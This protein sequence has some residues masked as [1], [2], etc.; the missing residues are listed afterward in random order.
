MGEVTSKNMRIRHPISHPPTPSEDWY[1]RWEGPDQGLICSWLR[2]IE[3]GLEDPALAAKAKAGEL[4]VLPWRGGVEKTIKRTD[5]VGAL[6]Y[7]AAWQGLR[8]EDLDIELGVE[9]QMTCTRTGVPVTFT[10]NTEQLLKEGDG[11]N[12]DGRS[13]NSKFI[14]EAPTQ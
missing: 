8:G 5:K 3:K 11:N 2:G 14:E 6:Q 4:P 10:G 7:L 1:E 9:V 12:N 13:E